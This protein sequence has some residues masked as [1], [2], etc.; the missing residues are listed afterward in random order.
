[1]HI[2]VTGT[3]GFIGKNLMVRLREAGIT[4]TSIAHDLDAGGYADALQGVTA[5]IHLAG[6]NRPKEEA[7]FTTGN[8]GMTRALV[9]ALESFGGATPIVYA[10]SIHAAGDSP[11]GSS[12]R[13]A[14]EVLTAYGQRTGAGVRI[15][16]LPGVFG[17]WCRPNYNSVVATFCHNIA[18]G[19]LIEISDPA[20]TLRLIYVDDLAERLVNLVRTADFASGP[21]EVDPVYT[22][23]LGEL[24]ALIRR[25]RDGRETLYTERVGTG[26]ERALHATYLSYLPP[27]SFGYPLKSHT[28]PR[29]TFAEVLRTLDS[30]Q[31]SFFTAHP[32]VTRG[33]HYHHSKTEK[34]LVVQGNARFGFRNVLTDEVHAIEVSGAVPT[35]IETVPGWSHDVTNIGEDTLVVLLWANEVFD[36]DRPDT[37]RA[38]VLP[39]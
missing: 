5:V 37:I 6:V 34:F 14:E 27:E 23:T 28:D 33:G 13:A 38:S 12:K 22:T 15:A 29:G 30:G 21:I 19:L 16:R 20:A 11:Y 35:V 31:F 9:A 24:A 10:S 32:G 8:T 7:D 4:A 39:A 26:F 18:R 25:F 2:G 17:K 1:M 36:P 3:N